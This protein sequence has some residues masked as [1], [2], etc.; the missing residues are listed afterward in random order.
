MMRTIITLQYSIGVFFSK[1]PL[2][3][4]LYHIYGKFKTN[5]NVNSFTKVKVLIKI[6][7]AIHF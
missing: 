7:V 2:L 6:L 1:F 4:T 3:F 5:L